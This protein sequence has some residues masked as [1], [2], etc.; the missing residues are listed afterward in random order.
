MYICIP[1]SM[2]CSNT[3]VRSAGYTSI[4]LE[5]KPIQRN[6]LVADGVEHGGD[7]ALHEAVLL[8]VVHVHHALPVVCH[9]GQAVRLT[10]VAQVEDILLEAGTPKA[11]RCM[12]ELG[13]DAG[14]CSNAPCNL[15]Q[16]HFRP[17]SGSGG[18]TSLALTHQLEQY[19]PSPQ[20]RFT[21]LCSRAVL[22]TKSVQ[23]LRKM[24]CDAGRTET[25][26]PVASQSAEMELMEEMRCAS[27]AFAV[28]LESSADHKLEHRM[29]SVG[30]Q[31]A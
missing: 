13:A 1:N 25:S 30:T 19:A 10:H 21:T 23:E 7:H 28:S 17:I 22:M 27:I 29:R 18:R 11:H 16:H 6:V 5:S 2:K 15:L 14:V 26:A 24:I 8:V 31:L 20:K 9:L 4:L 12:Q 3:K